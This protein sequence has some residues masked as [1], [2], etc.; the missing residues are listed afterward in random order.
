VREAGIAAIPLS[1]FYETDP[2]TS[3]IRL[4]Y[5]KKDQTLDEGAKRLARARELSRN[6]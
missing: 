6:R 2:V 4:C 1:A 3:I 5:A